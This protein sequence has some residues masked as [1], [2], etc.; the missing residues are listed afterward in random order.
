MAT[1]TEREHI[2]A[3]REREVR[4]AVENL[5]SE[6]NTLYQGCVRD[7]G[8]HPSAFY[9]T[10]GRVRYWIETLDRLTTKETTCAS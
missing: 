1:H 5:A 10:L 6:F 7:M 2:R 4:H 9:G 8:G 3:A